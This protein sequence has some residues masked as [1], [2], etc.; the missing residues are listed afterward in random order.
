MNMT[1]PSLRPPAVAGRFY[2]AEAGRLRQAVDGFLGAAQCPVRPALKAVVA[3]HAGYPY[4]GPIAGTA[5]RSI[6]K[7]ARPIRR[8]VLLGPS[9]HVAFDGL[10]LCEAKAWAT[11][12]G[13]V[14]VDEEWVDR[15][16]SHPAVKLRED[17]H[18]IEHCLEVELPFLQQT[19]GVFKLVPL[20]VG[21]ASDEAV[22]QVLDLL[23]GGPE[24]CLVVSSDLSH[25]YDYATANEL[26]RAT[27]AAIEELRPADIGP[28]HAC[29]RIPIRG[30]LR[31]ARERGLRA[32]TVDLRNS[33][34]TAGQPDSVVGYGAF[35]FTED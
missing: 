29:G 19:L 3:P 2:P 7:S 10:A 32:E 15:V 28:E 4:S 27:A 8:V 34:D 16:R 11:P 1:S 5:F 22:R 20:V 18:R 26:D 9:H 14:S 24:T 17:A 12:L 23:W 13:E 31:A 30:L 6:V 21:D 33:G 35:V 25:Y